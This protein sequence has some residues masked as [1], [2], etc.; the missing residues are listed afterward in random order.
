MSSETPLTGRA[1]QELFVR[2]VGGVG[3]LNCLV[4]V[5][6]ARAVP[7]GVGLKREKGW[8]DAQRQLSRG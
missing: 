6:R 1:A 5:G 2:S 4:L 3:R 8:D 7:G